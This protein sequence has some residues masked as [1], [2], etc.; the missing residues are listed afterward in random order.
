MFYD[1][2]V[3][4]TLQQKSRADVEWKFFFKS[5]WREGATG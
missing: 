5:G 1:E 2:R 4:I 3:V